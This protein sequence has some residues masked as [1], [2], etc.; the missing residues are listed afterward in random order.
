MPQIFLLY[1]TYAW[2]STLL[3]SCSEKKN[4]SYFFFFKSELQ[5]E[6][7]R[8]TDL[9]RTGSLL[10]WLPSQS[11]VPVTS[12][13]FPLSPKNLG[14]L[15]SFP[16]DPVIRIRGGTSGT[17]RTPEAGAMAQRLTPT[18][19]CPHPTWALVSVPAT[20]LPIQLTDIFSLGK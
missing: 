1:L 16:Q 15:L 2:T 20:P 7:Q 18:S 19:K 3:D 9:P 10:R 12:P 8:E 4:T 6:G 5:R 13:G 11:Q 17:N 14:H